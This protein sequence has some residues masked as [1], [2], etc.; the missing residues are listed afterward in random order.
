M[1]KERVDKKG[2]KLTP[3]GWLSM[4]EIEMD[5]ME[6]HRLPPRLLFL[7]C[8][9]TKETNE[10]LAPVNLLHLNNNNNNNILKG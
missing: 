6:F 3:E 2:N 9:R 4:D 10:L 1:E 8:C 5:F 7:W